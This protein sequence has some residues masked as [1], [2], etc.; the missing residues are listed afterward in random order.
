LD[1]LLH[2]G[3]YLPTNDLIHFSLSCHDFNKLGSYDV[4]WKEMYKY[5]YGGLQ[6]ETKHN[7]VEVSGVEVG[8]SGVYGWKA[9]YHQRQLARSNDVLAFN[10][11]PTVIPGLTELQTNPNFNVERFSIHFLQDKNVTRVARGI[12]LS[13]SDART[14]GLLG[15]YFDTLDFSNQSVLESL[16]LLL[17]FIQ[18]P[19]H[20]SV[21]TKFML[22]FAE[23]YFACNSNS[24]FKNSDAVYVLGF[25]IIMLN[26]DMHNSAVKNKMT[27]AQYIHNSSGINDG[28]NLPEKLLSDIYNQVKEKPLIFNKATNQYD[29]SLW[30]WV[31]DWIS[32]LKK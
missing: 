30:S 17:H 16:T 7:E 23:R 6:H 20:F 25:G 3:C 12:Y 31:S 26:T 9:R 14:S 2:V 5:E 22:Y 24:I 18:F 19:S 11:I 21:I 28:E 32:K 4:L 15:S 1:V 10:T 29:S 13:L 27:L 8:V